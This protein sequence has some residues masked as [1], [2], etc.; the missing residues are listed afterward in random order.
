[1]R[2]TA[3]KLAASMAAVPLSLLLLVWTG[4]GLF[5]I[6]VMASLPLIILYWIDLGAEIR[7]ASREGTPLGYLG[8]LM[9]VPQ[10][11]FGLACAGIG[12]AIIVWVLYNTFVERQS[13][14][15]GG[16]MTL[17]IGPLLVLFGAG[18]L[19]SAFGK[20]ASRAAADYA[21]PDSIHRIR[22]LPMHT[23]TDDTPRANRLIR[24][25][26]AAVIARVMDLA[27]HGE[28]PQRHSLDRL[29]VVGYCD[30]GCASVDFA[31]PAANE[32]PA[33]PWI[34]AQGKSPSGEDLGIILWT[35][36]DDLSSLELVSYSDEPAP[37]PLLSSISVA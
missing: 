5:F 21:A 34:H 28:A 3:V 4:N 24:L 20:D 9:G 10:A 35:N 15:S 26:E 22:S 16:F 7:T 37:L 23:E 14:Y 31:V 2:K 29:L 12:V 30:C 8:V 6:P 36:G 17:G 18:W 27:G 25:D 32:V 11:L 1:M 13:E 19:L 33:A